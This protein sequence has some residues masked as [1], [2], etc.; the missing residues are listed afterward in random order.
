MDRCGSDA[1][2]TV[3]G[4]RC[5]PRRPCSDPQL[6]RAAQQAPTFRAGVTHVTTDVIPR[7]DKGRF[8]PDLTK[9]NFTILEDGVAQTIDS[10]ALVH[11]GRTFNTHRGAAAGRARRHHPADRRRA[12]RSA[13]PPAACC[14]FSS[15]T[16]TSSRSTRRTSGGWSRRWLTTLLHEGDLVAMFSSGP[17]IDRDR[18]DLR[19]QADCGERVKDPRLGDDGR[20]RCSSCWRRR[21]ARAT[22]VSAR[23]WRLPV[24]L[25]RARPS[26]N[27][28][29]TS[30]RPMLYIST[31]YDFDPFAECAQGARPHPGWPVTRSRRDSCSTKKIPYFRLPAVNAD[32]DSAFVHARADAIGQSRQR[33]HLHHRPARVGG[34]RRRRAARSIRA[35]G[36]RFFRRRKAR[37]ATSPR[38][39]AASPSSTRTT[40][41]AAFKRIDAETSDYYVLGYYSSNPD[42]TQARARQLE[43]KVD[44]PGVT[45]ASRRAYSLKTPGTPPR[46]KK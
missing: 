17:S 44:R 20:L 39:P 24:G 22:C 18:A 33:H 28:S 42:P 29:R 3:A 45:V 11:G 23:R 2:L 36:G 12:G 31:G 15:T 25:R 21:R 27:G 38:K 43:V 40:S 41:T 19:S 37:Y 10:F 35:S 8:I 46:P 9:N 4:W 32:I 6:A 30:A 16:S 34:H 7:D 13:T 5:W 1:R 14:S 26:S